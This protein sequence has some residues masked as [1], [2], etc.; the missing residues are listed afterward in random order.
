MESS[1]IYKECYTFNFNPFNATACSC[2]Q[3]HCVQF[4]HSFMF[5]RDMSHGLTL[6]ERVNTLSKVR[7]LTE[8]NSKNS[9]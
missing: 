8:R 4:S 1:V 7:I 6:M 2:I 3:M 5:S 9:K